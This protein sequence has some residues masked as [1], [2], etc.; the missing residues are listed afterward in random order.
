MDKRY[1]VGEK[2]Y[3]AQL[4][5]YI[6]A[7]V[8]YGTKRQDYGFKTKESPKGMLIEIGLKNKNF[9]TAREYKALLSQYDVELF[10]P[11]ED[12]VEL[13]DLT[14]GA[15]I[16]DAPGIIGLGA[17][18]DEAIMFCLANLLSGEMNS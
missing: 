14:F 10:E 16:P 4:N 8:L 13:T 18:P 1:R 17:T 5:P 15:Y 7:G 12:L 2:V 3:D 6:Y 11:H 9:H